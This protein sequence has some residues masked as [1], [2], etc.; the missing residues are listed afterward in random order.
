MGAACQDQ[1]NPG[2][3]V[4]AIG[5]VVRDIGHTVMIVRG[6]GE[7]AENLRLLY[8]SWC[9]YE[10]VHTPAGCLDA[11]ITAQNGHHDECVEAI[12]NMNVAQ[13][14]AVREED[15]RE[16]DR[17]VLQRFGTFDAA[18]KLLGELIRSEYYKFFAA[19]YGHHGNKVSG[20][21]FGA[22]FYGRNHDMVRPTDLG[23]MEGGPSAVASVTSS[24]DSTYRH[25]CNADNP[26]CTCLPLGC[27][28]DQEF[29]AYIM[30][31]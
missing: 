1:R 11:F 28:D 29:H 5:D 25:V 30:L 20:E 16:I 2:T 10:I 4:R 7:P 9:V 15:K 18:N 13:A 26:S 3:D 27:N 22:H 14:Q 6:Q 12:N 31:L 17:L 24:K 21:A 23:G 19:G 8:R